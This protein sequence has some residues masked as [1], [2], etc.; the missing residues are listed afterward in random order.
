MAIPAVQ[1]PSFSRL[2]TW[3][4]TNWPAAVWILAAVIINIAGAK[5]VPEFIRQT[6]ALEDIPE[7]DRAELRRALSILHLSPE[8]LAWFQVFTELVGT[9]VNMA[10]GWLLVRRAMRTGFACYLAFVLLAL[11]NAEYP[12]SIAELL[13]GQPIAQTIIRLTTVIAIG[14]FFTLPFVFPDGRFVPR[15]TVLWGIY[16]HVGVFLFAF[17]PSLLPEG[18]PW[19]A[20][21]AVTTLLTIVSIVYAVVYR[22]RIVSTPEQRRQTRWVMFGLV[23]AVPGFFLGDAMMRNISASP[24]GVACL[25]GFLLIMPVAFTLPPVT[26]GIAILHQ[27]LFD[28]DVILNRTLVW[29]VMT[30]I[31]TGTYIGVV[32]GIG[33]LLGS[34]GNL[35][36][37][38]L[39]TG[40]VAVGFQPFSLRVQRLITRLLFGGRDD[41]YAVLARLGHHIE[42]SLNASDLLPQIVRTTAEALRLPYVA[43]FLE[44]ASG[45]ELVALSGVAPQ[46]TVRLP[47]TYQGRTVGALEVATRTPGEIFNPADRRLLEDLARQIGVAAR[48][49]SLATELQQSREQIVTSRE[50]ERRRLRRD[51]H[52]GLGAQLAGLI[53]QAGTA[54]RSIRT[55]PDAAE[56]TLLDLREELRSAVVDVRRLVLGLRPPALDELGLIGALRARLERWD[57]GGTDADTALRVLLRAEG[58][59]PPLRAATEVAAFRIAE[60]AVTNA[61]KHSRASSVTVTVWLRDDILH[62]TVADDGIGLASPSDGTG[63]GFQSMRERATELGGT[64]IVT[65][66]SDGHGTMVKATLPTAPRD[67]GHNSWNPSAF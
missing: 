18:Q 43:L 45:P 22:Y 5:L 29:L 64:C 9:I 54:R 8:H 4:V 53:M 24:L 41:P 23:I 32:V 28:I 34:V 61:V 6:I 3:L 65:V 11:T 1:Q 63:M 48:T 50:E 39:A 62:I 7:R 37:S 20:V 15:W 59:F 46:S 66:G 56:Q 16:N 14:G 26:L 12:P 38:L 33:S 44:Q 2:Q 42:D 27:R 31:V 47:L 21:E 10:I 57:G 36:L 17:A 55:D 49:V 25:L 13:P 30:I 40:V 52:D 51:L 35:L 58:S 67:G 60:E 19:I